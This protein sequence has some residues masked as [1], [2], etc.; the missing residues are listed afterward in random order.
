VVWTAGRHPP[1]DRT[2]L[3]DVGPDTGLVTP[4]E[5]GGA[6]LFSASDNQNFVDSVSFRRDRVISGLNVYTSSSHLPLVGTHIHV[7]I[8]LD[9]G[10]VPGAPL[11]ELDVVPTSI[12]FL[13]TFATANGQAADV[14]KVNLRFDPVQLNGGTT[15][16]VG[17]SGLRFDAGLYGVLGGV[18]GQMMLFSGDTLV[19]PAPALFGDLMFQLLSSPRRT[20]R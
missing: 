10:G 13:G 17:A 7:K 15:Y 11:V 5:G 8:L 18:D 12:T 20:S 14:H 1:R 2:I 3:Y 16:W 4:G 19:G 9:A 6:V